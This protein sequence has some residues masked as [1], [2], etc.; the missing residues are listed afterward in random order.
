MGG[1]ISAVD[2]RIKTSVLALAG[3]DYQR[4]LPEVDVLN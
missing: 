3:M 2:P 4:S 1:I